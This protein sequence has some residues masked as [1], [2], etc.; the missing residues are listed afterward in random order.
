MF[1]RLGDIRLG[2][3]H[4]TGP[5]AV[6]ETLKAD[7]VEH[8]TARG[9]PPLQDVGDGLDVSD[10]S[11]FFDE[12]FCDPSAEEAVLK[13]A[14]RARAPLPYVGGDGAY[15][16]THYVIIRLKIRTRKTTASGRTTRLDASVDLK[17]A[18]VPSLLNFS[19]S[20]PAVIARALSNPLT[21]SG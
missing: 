6:S 19:A 4:L 15:N 2:G 11:F 5:T 8:A 10:V 17:E 14:I 1:A 16:G 7:F 12:T 20:A 9:K 13:A 18:A 3:D 21:K